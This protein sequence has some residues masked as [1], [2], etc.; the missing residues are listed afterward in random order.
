MFLRLYEG[1][2]KCRKKPVNLAE[3]SV[4]C[5]FNPERC[6]N[7]QYTENSLRQIF[8]HYISNV[9]IP[10]VYVKDKGNLENVHNAFIEILL[11]YFKLFIGGSKIF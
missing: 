11:Y 2:P 5:L 3:K 10:Q 1:H 8:K 4:A 7:K 9:G 6:L